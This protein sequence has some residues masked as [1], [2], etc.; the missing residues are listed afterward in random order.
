MESEHNNENEMPESSP[1]KE[2]SKKTFHASAYSMSIIKQFARIIIKTKI[3]PS[4]TI[5]PN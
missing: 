5:F 4:S 2:E 1:S 3:H